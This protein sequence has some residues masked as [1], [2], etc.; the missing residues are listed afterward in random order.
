MERDTFVGAQCPL[1]INFNSHAHVERD[2]IA[3]IEQYV[4][5]NFNS[6]AHVERD[7][8]ARLYKKMNG[9]FQLTRSR[10]A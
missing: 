9:K 2:I 4:D 5:E 10:G 8:A 3:V 7:G 6:H 1:E